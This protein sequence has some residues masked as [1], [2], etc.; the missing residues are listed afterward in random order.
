MSQQDKQKHYNTLMSDIEDDD[1]ILENKSFSEYA[2]IL[3]RLKAAFLLAKDENKEKLNKLMEQVREKIANSSVN[4]QDK[5]AFMEAD[6]SGAL[7]G[8]DQSVLTKIRSKLF[9]VATTLKSNLK[10]REKE[11]WKILDKISLFNSQGKA[12]K[13]T[14]GDFSGI[15]DDLD[16]VDENDKPVENKKDQLEVLFDAA[17]AETAAEVIGN[18]K[19]SLEQVRNYLQTM[20]SGY[21][22]TAAGAGNVPEPN[23]IS[24]EQS[25]NR[26]LEN[27]KAKIQEFINTFGSKKTKI[28]NKQ[29]EIATADA[30]TE[31]EE[32]VK[33][34]EKDNNVKLSATGA[35]IQRIR[36]RAGKIKGW[37]F[38]VTENV[39][40]SRLT[41]S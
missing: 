7:E 25:Y 3:A 24:D 30:L 4:K 17:K 2:K 20:F 6:A 37:T 21:V 10:E 16:V 38:G 29:L 12:D 13:E 28:K 15:I 41:V 5:A 33:T 27:A 40:K 26:Y 11:V 19:I 31:A 9:N 34:L 36:E 39:V 8:V 22:I 14:F 1:K 35:Y 18:E 32:K 23:N